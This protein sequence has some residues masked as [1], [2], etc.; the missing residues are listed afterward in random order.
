M[1][2]EKIGGGTFSDVYF[3][4]ERKSTKLCAIKRFKPDKSE[5]IHYQNEILCLMKLDHVNII[6]LKDSYDFEPLN[7]VDLVFDFVD[8]TLCNYHFRSSIERIDALLQIASGLITIHKKNIVH[9]DLKPENIL[10][11][12]GGIVKIADFGSSMIL[13]KN[14]IKYCNNAVTKQYRSKE[15]LKGVSICSTSIDMWS[16][17]CII[18]EVWTK[19][20]LFNHKCTSTHLF[21][22]NLIHKDGLEM[23]LKK[24]NTKIPSKL[25]KI[26]EGC[27]DVDPIKRLTAK[28]CFDLLK[29]Y[30]EILKKPI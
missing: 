12:K 24:I 15:L 28:Q 23:F 6:K 21:M 10:I 11:T 20:M 18:F 30:L 5:C 1:I 9:F 14:K 4:Y 19:K 17:G 2:L 7:T 25:L 16:F 29:N 3:A 13:D 27:L 22:I 8:F 26:I